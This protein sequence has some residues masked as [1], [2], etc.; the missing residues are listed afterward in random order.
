VTKL[1]RVPVQCLSRFRW[2]WQRLDA[3]WRWKPWHHG[4]HQRCVQG[5]AMIRVESARRLAALGGM[6]VE[7]MAA[8]RHRG[9]TA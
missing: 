5:C 9:G 8:P 3:W 2:G 4:E 7:A 1:G 6:N